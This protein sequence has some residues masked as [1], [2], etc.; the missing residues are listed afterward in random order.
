MSFRTL[1]FLL[2][3][4]LILASCEEDKLEQYEGIWDGSYAGDEVGTMTIRIKE[5][6]ISQGVAYPEEAEEGQSFVFT[7]SV[8]EDGEITMTANVFGRVATYN[9]FVTETELT[10]S[11][12]ADGGNFQGT[13]SATKRVNEDRFPYNT[14]LNP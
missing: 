7:G 14:L 8:N 3:A 4:C 12:I 13:W 6:G 11:W 5:D 1:S 9:A 10:G 2:F